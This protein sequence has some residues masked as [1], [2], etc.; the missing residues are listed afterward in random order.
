MLHYRQ[1]KGEEALA[2]LREI[3][4]AETT[5]ALMA[6]SGFSQGMG[7]EGKGIGLPVGLII[8]AFFTLLG[9]ALLSPVGLWASVASFAVALCGLVGGLSRYLAKRS[10]IAEKLQQLAKLV[11]I[12]GK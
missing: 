4:D 7:A 8:C 2:K 6:I 1:P 9:I 5:S 3:T 12:E 11:E 10:K